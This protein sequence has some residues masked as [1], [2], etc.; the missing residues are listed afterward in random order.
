MSLGGL[1]SQSARKDWIERTVATEYRPVGTV[2]MGQATDERLRVLGTKGLRVID[3]SVMP[4]HVCANTVATVYAIAEKG[5]GLI[6]EG[7][8][9]ESIGNMLS[10][11]S[12]LTC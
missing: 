8:R 11:E 9:L 10:E 3:A 5:S 12:V 7:S 2:T 6:K 4:L 1:E